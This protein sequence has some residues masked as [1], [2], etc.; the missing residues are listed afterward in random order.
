MGRRKHATY[1]ALRFAET[2]CTVHS[3][4]I[5]FTKFSMNWMLLQND[6]GIPIRQ[7]DDEV[8]QGCETRTRPYGCVAFR[9]RLGQTMRGH[10]PCSRETRSESSKS[11]ARE[12]Q[13]ARPSLLP[14]VISQC[15][16]YHVHRLCLNLRSL[17]RLVIQVVART[18]YH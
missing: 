4:P 7:R 5:P 2:Y 9:A 6:P 17:H 12:N 10:P 8:P 18:A 13:D 15:L 14:Q 3:L 16:N 1:L 11:R